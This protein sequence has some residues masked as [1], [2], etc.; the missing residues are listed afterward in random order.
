MVIF[1]RWLYVRIFIFAFF[2]ALIL[3]G[4]LD[5]ISIFAY[6][7]EFVACLLAAM[8]LIYTLYKKEIGKEFFFFILIVS[9]YFVYSLFFGKNVSQAV[10]LDAII[11]LKCFIPFYVVYYLKFSLSLKVR[12]FFLKVI[13]ILCIPFIIIGVYGRTAIEYYMG[14]EALYAGCIIAMS[15]LYIYCSSRTKKDIII[16]FLILTIGLLSTRSKFYGFYVCFIFVFFVMGR[17]PKR[18]FTLKNILFAIILL[19]AVVFV[20]REKIYDYIVTGWIDA[21]SDESIYARPALY[22]GMIEILKRYPI[23]GS[24][25]GSYATF[26]SAEYYSP[27]YYELGLYKIWGLSPDTANFISD[28]YYP[29]LAEYGLVGIILFM[30]F[31]YRRIQQTSLYFK[32]QNRIVEYKSVVLIIIY[33]FIESIADSTLLQ[34]RGMFMMML[35]ALFLNEKKLFVHNKVDS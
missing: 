9:F 16:A 3:Y 23:L 6:S 22:A 29:S 2:I 5:D 18:F 33:F 35:L 26:A 19:V 7:D 32:K 11:L 12:R 4:Y 31:W 17:I 1:L 25:M 15:F 13:P 28:T 30:L 8:Y 24:G 14:F 10:F 20:V 27:L 34:N 21:T